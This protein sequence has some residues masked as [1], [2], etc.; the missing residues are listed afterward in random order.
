MR[1]CDLKVGQTVV[2]SRVAPGSYCSLG[3]A[4]R[5]ESIGKRDVSFRNV[6]MG[7][8]TF[9]PKSLLRFAEF[10]AV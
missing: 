3:A 7:S 1:V 2:F 5:V 9:D 8:G 6:E 10:Q 4:Y